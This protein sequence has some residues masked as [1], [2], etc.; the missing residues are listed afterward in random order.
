MSYT[1][2]RDFMPEHEAFTD[3]G[4]FIQ[5]EKLGGGTVGHAYEGTWRYVVSN[6]KGEEI[7]RAQ[8]FE[9]RTPH[10]HGQAVAVIA[11]YFEQDS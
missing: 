5:V 1:D 3:S 2:L 9:T 7:A 6:E 10:T 11:G 4:L 8:D